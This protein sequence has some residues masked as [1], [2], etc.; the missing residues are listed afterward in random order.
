MGST[1]PMLKCDES[2]LRQLNPNA[3]A[4]DV[5]ADAFFVSAGPK[6]V[7]V[8]KTFT[9]EIYRLRDYLREHGVRSVAIDA[10]GVYWIT[11]YEVLEEAGFEVCVING[12]QA[13]NL[14]GRKSDV[15]DCQ[16]Y[17]QM[18]TFGLLRPAFIAPEHIRQLRTYVRLREDHIEMASAHVQHMQKAL[19]LMN[20]KLG[21]VI[22][23]IHGASG[24]RVIRAILDG[25]RKAE[26]LAA[27][28]DR[29]I[30]KKKR[31]L[32]I[33][34]LQGNFREEH[35][36]SLAQ[37]LRCWEFY[38]GMV[39]ECDRQIEQMLKQCTREVPAPVH[40]A[41][42]KRIRRHQPNVE[43]FHQKMVQFT[44]GND[45]AQATG[46]TDVSVL[47]L[48]AETGTDMTNWAT[49][50]HF[51]SWARLAPQIESSGKMRRS[52]G[53]RRRHRVGQIFRECAMGVARSQTALGAFYRRIQARRG[54]PVAMVATA[55]KIAGIY[56]D[57][58]RHGREF[59]EK[60]QQAYEQQQNER[61][62]RYLVKNAEAL[63]YTLIPT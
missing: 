38:Q 13:K 19:D 35:L 26:T 32:V 15:L 58:L 24:M 25:V 45:L 57:M 49:K 47:K 56:Y 5:G 4:I 27:L 63:G 14:P 17:Q 1:G 37:A 18:H 8:F 34:S 46:L 43:D 39:A 54:S 10:A 11:L 52:R 62:L 2:L 48:V 60:G 53:R 29:R 59:V 40:L 21:R 50:K 42:A 22:S 41:P 44:G 31:D 6:M 61:R 12:G 23:E 30:L 20:V 33:A 51:T 55:R 9:G 16:W 36:F 7:E 28:C 3:A